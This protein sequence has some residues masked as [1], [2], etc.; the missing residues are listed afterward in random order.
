M[1]TDPN[2]EPDSSFERLNGSQSEQRQKTVLPK[3]IF[4][5]TSKGNTQYSG[6]ELG[7]GSQIYET[8]E[9]PT[10]QTSDLQKRGQETETD[11]TMNLK[12][13]LRNNR[14]YND[15]SPESGLVGDTS[16]HEE[17]TRTNLNNK[18]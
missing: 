5:K 17:T 2:D 10:Y 15:R 7:Q 8:S 3:I 4:T 12:S 13:A 18:N 9:P 1:R 14:S 16:I 6:T 11:P